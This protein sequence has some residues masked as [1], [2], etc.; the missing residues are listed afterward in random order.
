MHIA[1]QRQ[2]TNIKFA[3]EQ[4]ILRLNYI[5]AYLIFQTIYTEFKLLKSTKHLVIFCLEISHDGNEKF[6]IFC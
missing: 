4:N 2:L 3:Y 6:V 5:K 1:Q